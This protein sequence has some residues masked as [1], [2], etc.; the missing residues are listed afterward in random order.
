MVTSYRWIDQDIKAVREG[1][2]ENGKRHDADETALQH[3]N[4]TID[5]GVVEQPAH[6]GNGED[7]LH[8]HRSAE[9]ARQPQCKEGDDRQRAVADAV[10]HDGAM[11]AKATAAG[12]RDVGG[13]QNLGHGGT[14]HLCEIGERSER[15]RQRRQHQRAPAVPSG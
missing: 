9:Q 6:A 15:E 7:Y 11:H 2:D 5:H 8:D 3:R 12:R 14:R 10:T 1:V 13:T 4:V